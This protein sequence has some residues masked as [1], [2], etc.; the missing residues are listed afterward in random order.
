MTKLLRATFSI[1]C[2]FVASFTYGG[3]FVKRGGALGS[4]IWENVSSDMTFFFFILC[5]TKMC[6]RGPANS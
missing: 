4:N 3:N 1:Q 5:P 6:D 2:Q